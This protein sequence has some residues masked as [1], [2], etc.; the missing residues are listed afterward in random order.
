M[1]SGAMKLLVVEDDLLIQRSL[2]EMVE[3]WGH[4]CDEAL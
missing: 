4:A 1:R 2:C 3:A